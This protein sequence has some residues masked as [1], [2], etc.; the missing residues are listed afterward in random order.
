MTLLIFSLRMLKLWA[1]ISAPL[2]DTYVRTIERVRRYVRAK[3]KLFMNLWHR[4]V[5]N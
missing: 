2:Y 5:H 3:F 4:A 1:D